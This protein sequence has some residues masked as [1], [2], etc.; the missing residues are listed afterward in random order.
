MCRLESTPGLC[1]IIRLP[2]S[3]GSRALS[4]LDWIVIATYLL[5]MLCLTLWRGRGPGL[6]LM[7]S[8]ATP[9]QAARGAAMPPLAAVVAGLRATAES[10]RKQDAGEQQQSDDRGGYGGHEIAHRY[11]DDAGKQGGE[12]HPENQ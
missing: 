9:P 6:R 7:S 11:F 2:A 1:C 8:P 10:P 4:L 12:E 3:R 5:G